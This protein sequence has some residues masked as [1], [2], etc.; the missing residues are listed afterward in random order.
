M[1]ALDRYTSAED[2]D[3][4]FAL[5]NEEAVMELYLSAKRGDPDVTLREIA[6]Q[7]RKAREAS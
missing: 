4:A 5:E 6:K 7:A 1:I 3:F 2:A